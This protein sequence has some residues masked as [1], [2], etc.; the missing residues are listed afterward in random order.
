MDNIELME[1]VKDNLDDI[2]LIIHKYLKHIE[3]DGME[4]IKD[5]THNGCVLYYI[6]NG[7]K[8]I[9]KKI[10]GQSMW[11]DNDFKVT[12]LFNSM[13]IKLSKFLKRKYIICKLL[14]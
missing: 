7:S 12:F 10:S 9:L 4:T 14:N 1:F 8:K 5:D 11:I 3:Y 6:F 2:H 13:D